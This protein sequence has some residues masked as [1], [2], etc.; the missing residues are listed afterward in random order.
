[1][2]LPK[3]FVEPGLAGEDVEGNTCRAV[4][5]FVAQPAV[6][7]QTEPELFLID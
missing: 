2:I 6:S 4:L 5:V 3:Q 7:I 1:M